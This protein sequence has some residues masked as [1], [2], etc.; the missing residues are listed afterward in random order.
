MAPTKVLIRM[1]VLWAYQNDRDSH[2]EVFQDPVARQRL[3][4]L[5]AP[6]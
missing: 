3:L 6:R 2:K 5:L 1:R 4:S